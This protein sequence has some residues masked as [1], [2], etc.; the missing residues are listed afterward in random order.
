MADRVI[1]HID[2]DAFFA[3]VE[4]RCDPNLDGKAVMVAGGLEGRTVVAAATY[5]ARRFGVRSGTPLTIA[6]LRCPNGIFLEGDPEKYVFTSLRLLEICKEFTP[7]VE[8]YS[9]DESFLDITDTTE[10]FGG[11]LELARTLKRRFRERFHLT[12]S[13]G[14]GLNKLLAKTASKL[15]KPDGLATLWREEIPAK[16]WPL[17][18][19]KL[20]GVGEQTAKKL[21]LLGI[22]TIGELA[23]MPVGP[24]A[25]LFGVVGEWLHAA[26]N[27]LDDSP[28]IPEDDEPPPKSVGNDYT[29]QKDS[30]DRELLHS[31]LLALCS[32]VGRRLRQGGHAGRTVTVKMRFADFTTTT[33]TE[34]LEAYMDMDGEIYAVARRI[35]DTALERGAVRLLGVSVSNLVHHRP[36]RQHSLFDFRARSRCV[37]AIEAADR[38]RDKF[39]ERS[40]VWGTLVRSEA[41]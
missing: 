33:R 5:E 30:R 21:H 19:H 22:N 17:P 23:R 31:V 32:K 29:L 26:A 28:V 10:R 3:S 40:I 9:I 18:I 6:R 4:Q 13:V 12:A 14:L 20:F 39:G 38:I 34:T 8:H 35:L 25:Q 15:D 27:G 41:I 7:I 36:L 37:Q 24:L 1:L 2:M 16:F 11:P